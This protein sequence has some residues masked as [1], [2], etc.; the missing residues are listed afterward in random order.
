MTAASHAAAEPAQLGHDLFALLGQEEPY[1]PAIGGVD[2]A[3]D[4]PGH[5]E[6]PC[7]PGDRTLIDMEVARERLLRDVLA[8][9]EAEDDRYLSGGEPERVQRLVQG[10]IVML[11]HDPEESGQRHFVGQEAL[12]CR[13]NVSPLQR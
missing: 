3:P 13:N 1:G 10:G 8:G 12:R 2:L 7:G 11:E 9:G 5:L 6:P 4:E